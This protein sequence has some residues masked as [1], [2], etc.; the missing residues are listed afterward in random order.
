MIFGVSFGIF[1]GSKM[2]FGVLKMILET[3]KATKQTPKILFQTP[4]NTNQGPK[5]IFETPIFIFETSKMRKKSHFAASDRQKPAGQP[6]RGRFRPVPDFLGGEGLADRANSQ[7][8]PSSGSCKS[9]S[10]MRP[11]RRSSVASTSACRLSARWAAATPSLKTAASPRAT[12]CDTHRLGRLAPV[13]WD[14]EP[15]G[16]LVPL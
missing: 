16:A 4:K 11:S 13:R 3:P 10:A 8:V 7:E 12:P 15:H 5:N 2:V 14:R 6:G 1:G 9:H